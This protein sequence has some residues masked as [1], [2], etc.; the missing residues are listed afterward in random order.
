MTE[1]PQARHGALTITTDQ[2][3]WTQ[4]QLAALRQ[5]WN[6]KTPGPGDQVRFLN[7][8]QRS[9]LDPFASQVY[10]IERGGKW[11]VQTAIDGFR[12]IR[13]RIAQQRHL[14]VGYEDTL[15]CGPDGGWTDAWLVK[16]SP[17]AAKVT[18][19]VHSDSGQARF[20]QVALWSEYGSDS[21]MWRKMPTTML[22]KVAEAQA[23]RRAFPH[24]LSG[25]YTSDEMAQAG[26]QP[27]PPAAPQEQPD[28]TA[29]AHAVDGVLGCIIAA[30]SQDELRACWASLKDHGAVVA[31]AVVAVPQGWQDADVPAQLP[32]HRLV[33]VAKQHLDDDPYD[34]QGGSPP[35]DPWPA[36]AQPSD[37][38]P[39]DLPADGAPLPQCAYDGCTLHAVV[40][41]LWCVAHDPDGEAADPRQA[42]RERGKPEGTGKAAMAQARADLAARQAAKAT[43]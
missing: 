7:V 42:D 15:F 43:L 39:D 6:G 24:D 5:L 8:C 12:V 21:S 36:P 35:A 20:S 1:Q 38:H 3:E 19:T 25:L 40:A 22:A 2:Q 18:V 9:G 10:F 29:L 33:V 41:D 13:D 17:A 23:L 14:A 34:D 30:R 28:P 4:P 37:V 26:V 27:D 31:E 16:G 32:L 11:S